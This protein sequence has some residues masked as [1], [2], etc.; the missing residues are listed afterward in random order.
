MRDRTINLSISSLLTVFVAIASCL[1]LWQLR[2][3]LVL[4]MVAIV[5][6]TAIAPIVDYGE[7]IW[8]PRWLSAA[9]FYLFAILVLVGVFL[10]IG[11][12]VFEQLQRLIRQ[13]PIVT[14]KIVALAEEKLTPDESAALSD[15]V[16]QLFDLQT[17]TRWTIQTGQ[18]FVLRSY[19]IT[20][21]IV[22]AVL[23]FVLA[24][25]FSGYMLADSDRLVRGL[26]QLLPEPWDSRI[27]S[28][29]G[30]VGYRMGTY[31]RG[32]LLVSIILA[33][34]TTFGLRMLGLAEFSLALGAIAGVTNLVPF[35]GPI[36]GAIPA[37]VV[38]IAQ[39]GWLVLWVLI[40]YTIVQNLET[41]LLDPLLVGSAVGVHPLYQLLSVIG[42]VQVLGILGAAIVPPWFA[43]A[44]VIVENLYLKP[45]Q[46]AARLRKQS[47]SGE[48]TSQNSTSDDQLADVGA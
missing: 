23:S 45:K 40:L 11:P 19:S 13:V 17:L 1:L 32:R 8:L 18:E 21:G 20:R 38:A 6:A 31:L 47:P 16:R 46:E 42:G 44:S 3:V 4:L 2:G 10:L 9:L 35:I 34:V 7:R 29:M 33:V 14:E 27:Q 28:Q 24:L 37:L 25:F 43:G 15:L 36:L 12:Q 41:Y 5:L 26:S 48:V 30:E 39:G 22:G